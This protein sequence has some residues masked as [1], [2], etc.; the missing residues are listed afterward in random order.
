VG[1]GLAVVQTLRTIPDSMVFNRNQALLRLSLKK[2]SKRPEA[3][4]AANI[5]LGTDSTFS[6]YMEKQYPSNVVNDSLFF[7]MFPV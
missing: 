6:T 1:L 2:R 7:S 4:R 3:V 5:L